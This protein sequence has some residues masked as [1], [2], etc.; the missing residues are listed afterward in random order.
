MNLKKKEK[1]MKPWLDYIESYKAVS[2]AAYENVKKL[3]EKIEEQSESLLWK[4]VMQFHSGFGFFELEN[5]VLQICKLLDEGNEQYQS[6]RIQMKRAS[7][8][9]KDKSDQCGGMGQQQDKQNSYYH[10]SYDKNHWLW[11]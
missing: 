2:I 1:V 6:L 11:W 5:E 8:R 10:T 9:K 3:R 7:D 4:A